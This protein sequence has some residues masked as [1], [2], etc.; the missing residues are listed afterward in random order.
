M[1]KD[2][3]LEH[4]YREYRKHP[5]SEE[6]LTRIVGLLG[7]PASALLRMRDANAKE[8]GLTGKEPD[9]V[10]I[11]HMARHP[12]LVQRPIGIKGDRAVIGRPVE[13]LL[14]L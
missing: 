4:T 8:L 6:E 9:A 12:T 13:K 5:L 10:L 3:G 11:P 2:R 7:V 14:E 1:L